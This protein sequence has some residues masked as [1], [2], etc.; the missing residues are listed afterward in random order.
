[1]KVAR[2]FL[3]AIFLGGMAC[4]SVQTV[5]DP[6]RFFADARPSYV[7]V[8]YTDNSE[9]PVANPQ[10]RGDTIVG[11]W[12]G[13][14]EPVAVPMDEV[15]RIDAMQKDS[16]KTTV[17]IAALVGVAVVTGYGLYRAVTDY[18]EICDWNRPTG[19]TQNDDAGPCYKS[20][21]RT[22]F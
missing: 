9:V 1:M 2:L 19:N 4:S 13:L 14:G 6:A 7:V 17:F 15:Q 18:G 5:R 22:A 16:R 20:S 11:E 8:T 12:R 3:A 21:S 10:M